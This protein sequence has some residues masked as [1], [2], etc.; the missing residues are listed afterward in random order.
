MM[1][2]YIDKFPSFRRDD[3]SGSLREFY[4]LYENMVDNL[5]YSVNIGLTFYASYDIVKNILIAIDDYPV[6]ASRDDDRSSRSIERSVVL[7]GYDV[8]LRR[9]FIDAFDPRPITE[10]RP[11]EAGGGLEDL[12][13]FLL[14]QNQEMGIDVENHTNTA[15][16]QTYEPVP[17]VTSPIGMFFD[18]NVHLENIR[19]NAIPHSQ[20]RSYE[21]DKNRAISRFEPYY[22]DSINLQPITE[23]YYKCKTIPRNH[24]FDM[25]TILEFCEKR[26]DGIDC[27][28]CPT[29][30]GPMDMILYIQTNKLDTFIT[31]GLRSAT[32][33]VDSEKIDIKRLNIIDKLL[34]RIGNVD[35]DRLNLIDNLL[36]TVDQLDYHYLKNINELVSVSKNLDEATLMEE[37]IYYKSFLGIEE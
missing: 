30:K 11:V 21:T 8:E 31:N 5:Q 7:Q 37:I 6:S 20:R 3:L 34:L 14:D 13:E 33:F 12:E 18:R 29:C 4:S 1:R 23:Y 17:A 36:Q 35:L 26:T 16:A 15:H 9:L 28:I 32:D 10:I 24:S 2:F 25:R 27:K 19:R 22:M